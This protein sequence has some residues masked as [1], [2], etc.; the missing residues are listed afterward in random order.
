MGSG[1]RLGQVRGLGSAKH[2]ASHWLTHRATAFSNLFLTVWLVVSLATMPQLDHGT[3]TAWMASPVTA[4][5]MILLILSVFTHFR[6]G[7]QEL[8]D[9]YIHDHGSKFALMLL[10]NFYV[11]GGGALGI[12]AVAR[13]AFAG[14]A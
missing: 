13:V 2:G 10:L 7:L 4:V 3:V 9:D 12:F 5:A 11:F 6:F 8:I 1:T 14:A